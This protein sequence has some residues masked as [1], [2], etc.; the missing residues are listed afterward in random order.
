VAASALILAGLLVIAVAALGS[1]GARQPGRTPAAAASPATPVEAPAKTPLSVG[2]AQQPPPQP[3][4]IDDF[5]VI[6]NE[7]SAPRTTVTIDRHAAEKLARQVSK[8]RAGERSLLRRVDDIRRDLLR[9]A[10]LRGNYA[11]NP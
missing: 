2:T 11:P 3:A 10:G 5:I 1:A 7:I 6:R 8:L 9:S 4:A